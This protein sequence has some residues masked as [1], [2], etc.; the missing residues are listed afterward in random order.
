M[1][2]C[3]QMSVG[4]AIV[5]NPSK[6]RNCFST[7]DWGYVPTGAHKPKVYPHIGMGWTPFY[8][9]SRCR[10]CQWLNIYN[11]AILHLYNN[12]MMQLATLIELCL[13]TWCISFRSVWHYC[14]HNWLNFLTLNLICPRIWVADN[15]QVKRFSI[16]WKQQN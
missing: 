5:G 8:C 7:I 4:L 2:V 6:V 16:N 14:H 11:C 3:H 15:Y 9:W 10:G 13:T 12:A 1:I